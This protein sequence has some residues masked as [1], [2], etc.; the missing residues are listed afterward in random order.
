YIYCLLFK[1]TRSLG[2]IN[3]GAAGDRSDQYMLQAAQSRS[4]LDRPAH[5]VLTSAI[6]RGH[7]TRQRTLD[8]F[9]D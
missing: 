5:G 4:F 7:C 1:N 3:P 6:R 9:S 2:L 8:F